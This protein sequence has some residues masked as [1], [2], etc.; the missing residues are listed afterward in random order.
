MV[1]GI[2]SL[3]LKRQHITLHL[4]VLQFVSLHSKDWITSNSALGK[5]F[6]S[7]NPQ[8]TPSVNR[9]QESKIHRL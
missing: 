7:T 3:C 1:A 9:L 8:N 4:S 6:F 2:K 5:M